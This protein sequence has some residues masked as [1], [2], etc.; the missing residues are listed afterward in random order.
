MKPYGKKDGLKREKF[1]QV[2]NAVCVQIAIG[3]CRNAE[4][5]VIGKRKKQNNEKRIHIS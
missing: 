5:A 2:M 1:I 4:N 3:K